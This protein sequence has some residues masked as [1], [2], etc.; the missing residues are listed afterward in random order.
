MKSFITTA[1]LSLL[2]LSTIAEAQ[3][4]KN[5]SAVEA[6]L[7]ASLPTQDVDLSTPKSSVTFQ[8]LIASLPTFDANVE[9]PA[10]QVNVANL[11]ASLPTFD[12][13]VEMPSQVNVANLMA[14][15]P[16]FD[17]NVE[18]PVSRINSSKLMASL[19]TMDETTVTSI[20][21]DT[22]VKH[23]DTKIHQTASRLTEE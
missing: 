22:D 23:L 19:P 7:M 9:M 3:P 12:A 16:T 2:A 18:M 13:N 10:S 8:S 20:L 15:L 4:Q 6:H 14:S 17:T 11:I 1:A 5:Q 21:V